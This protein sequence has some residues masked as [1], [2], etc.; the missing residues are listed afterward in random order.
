MHIQRS[1]IAMIT[2][3]KISKLSDFIGYTRTVFSCLFISV[4]LGMKYN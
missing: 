2:H 3:A 1:E 4:A